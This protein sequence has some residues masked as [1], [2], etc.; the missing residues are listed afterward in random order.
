MIFWGPGF[1]AVVWFGSSPT[2]LPSTRSHSFLVFLCVT[3]R[4]EVWG[5]GG[6]E[7]KSYDCKKAWSSINHSILAGLNGITASCLWVENCRG[8][9]LEAAS[10]TQPEHIIIIIITIIIIR[11]F[12]MLRRKDVSS[13]F[14]IMPCP[15]IMD[16]ISIRT[17]NPKFRL[18]WCLIEFIDWRYSQSCWLVFSTPLVN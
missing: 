11:L 16:R 1:L 14:Q 15:V 6:G 2:P 7:A 13:Q 4:R 9:S 8:N 5:G 3:G 18:Y 10:R 17:P 12:T